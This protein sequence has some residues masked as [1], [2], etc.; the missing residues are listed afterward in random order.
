M[1]SSFSGSGYVHGSA[2]EAADGE[3]ARSQRRRNLFVLAGIVVAVGVGAAALTYSH[4]NP[5][6]TSG[7]AA[8]GQTHVTRAEATKC[9]RA[10]RAVVVPLVPPPSARNAKPAF[11]G[12]PAVYVTFPPRPLRSGIP[13]PTVILMFEPSRATAQRVVATLAVHGAR[14]VQIKNNVVVS[15]LNPK[16]A[17]ASRSAVLG[18]V[19]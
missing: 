1:G 15:W 16:I 3:R 5:P 7:V 11:P 4:W 19:D 17:S 6:Q 13:R 9:L 18:C 10:R 12:A 2:R 8:P 14:S